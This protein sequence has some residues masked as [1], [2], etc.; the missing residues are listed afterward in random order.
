M[1]AQNKWYLGGKQPVLATPVSVPQLEQ[2]PLPGKVSKHK[3]N[4]CGWC[5]CG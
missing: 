5:E 2:G 4:T 1:N 3:R